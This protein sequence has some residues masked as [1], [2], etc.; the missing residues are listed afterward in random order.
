MGNHLVQRY[1]KKSCNLCCK[2]ATILCVLKL[3]FKFKYIFLVTILNIK[4]KQLTVTGI[5]GVPIPLAPKHVGEEC[6]KELERVQE[7]KE[8]V[9]VLERKHN[10]RIVTQA[11][12][13]AQVSYIHKTQIS[14]FNCVLAIFII[15]I[16]IN[17][18]TTQFMLSTIIKYLT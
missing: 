8:E 12:A 4:F 17:P 10:L 3:S 13:Q 11:F 1:C 14:T 6:K 2:Q 16:I 7:Q 15:I 9:A 5:I 18:Q